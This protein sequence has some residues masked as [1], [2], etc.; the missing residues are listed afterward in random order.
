MLKSYCLNSNDI[1]EL[2]V[3]LRFK[4]GNPQVVFPHGYG[5]S[6]DDKECR[7]DIFLLLSVLEKFS[8][9]REGETIDKKKTV[10]FSF[11][12]DSY[13]YI[14][15]D[16]FQN[17]YY[18]ENE[19]RYI[20]SSRGKI[21]WKRTIQKEKP[22]I[23]N[24]NVV[25]LDFQVK[26]NQIS[27][28]NLLTQIHRY[29]V[30]KSFFYFGW[31]FFS[32]NYLPEK[33]QIPFNEK[34]FLATLYAAMSKTFDDKKRMLFQCMINIIRFEGQEKD[35]YNFTCGVNRFDPVWER[36][37]DCV[38]GEQDKEK[39]FPHA[40]W[41]IIRNKKFEKSSALE[42]DTIMKYNNKTFVLDAKYYKF[43]ITEL[44]SDLPA[45]A[46]IQKQITYSKYIAENMPE[47]DNMNIYNA[48]IM[49]YESL[50]HEKMKFVSIATA[51]WETYNQNTFNY[52]YVVGILLDT[53][54]LLHNFRK[55]NE[56]EIEKMAMK[57]E[58]SLSS[59]RRG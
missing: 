24:D 44:A 51:D 34:I 26:T 1:S 42:P 45:T 22:Q 7:K 56:S 15:I 19:V 5:I 20:E 13:H 41:H 28:N 59:Y 16:Y 36:I 39:Y 57:I 47:V 30:Y 8:T 10:T 48:F 53:K 18:V 58:E 33:P 50:D 52:A 31:L 55:H 29:C 21:N 35:D 4:E 32:E 11:P 9:H 12:F 6:S 25:Y 40:T 43:G 37:I 23:D 17:G 49:P 2:F 14:I 38:F 3:G 54:H 27:E 46:S